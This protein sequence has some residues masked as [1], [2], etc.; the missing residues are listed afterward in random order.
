MNRLEG[1]VAVVTGGARG[2][3]RSIVDC[4]LSEGAEAV[5]CVDLLDRAG[6][7]PERYCHI[8]ASVTDRAAMAALAEQIQSRFGQADIL[9]NNAGITRDALLTK[10]TEDNWDDVIDVNLKGAFCITQ[11]LA[12]AMLAS[13]KGSIVNISSP[14]GECG[15]IGQSN[16]AAA[17]AGLIGLTLTWAKEF[18]RKGGAI[19]VNAVAPGYIET[20]MVRT[21]PASMLERLRAENPLGRLGKPEEVA[22][23]VRFLASDETS[24]ING[25]VLSVNGGQ[26]G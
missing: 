10:L 15:N 26:V 25:H 6:P 12:P 8:K 18:L 23:A 13:G 21:I 19:R 22:A 17:K 1:K 9:V 5:Y 14:S 7:A 3:G 2:I 20:D 11:A 4:F 16:Y 24:Y